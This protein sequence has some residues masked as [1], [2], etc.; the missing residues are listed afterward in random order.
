MSNNNMEKMES[1]L[2]ICIHETSTFVEPLAAVEVELDCNRLA[3]SR[4]LL[5]IR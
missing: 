3:I 4:K 1:S 5:L 2:D